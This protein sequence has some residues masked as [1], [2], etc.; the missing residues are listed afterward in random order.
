MKWLHISDLHFNFPGY[1]SQNLKDK[2]IDLLKELSFKADFILVTG[3]CLYQHGGTNKTRKEL[4]QFFKLISKTCS[5]SCGKIYISQGNHDVNRSDE[6]R[7]KLIDEIRKDHSLFSEKY[8]VL[9]DIGCDKFKGIYHEITGRDYESFKAFQPR[10]NNCR[11]ISINTTLLSKDREDSGNLRVCNQKLLELGKSIKDDH[12]INILIMHHGLEYLD[13]EDS[14]KFEHWMDDN[15]ID[16]VF[17]GHSHRAA[18]RCY[19]DTYREIKQI[20]AGAIVIDDYAIPSFQLCEYDEANNV[21]T[22]NLFTYSKDSEKWVPD[23]QRLRTYKDGVHSYRLPRKDIQNN[24]EQCFIYGDTIDEF[25]KKYHQRYNSDKIYSNK[26]EGDDVFNSWK[27]VS[28]LVNIGMSYNRALII[29]REVIDRITHQDFNT[30]HKIL[31]CF[32]LRKII[33][34]T[35]IN[36]TPQTDEN[37]FEVSRWAS[38][39]SRKYNRNKEILIL[40][41]GKEVEKLNYSYIKNILIKQIIDD[42]TQNACYYKKLTGQELCQMAESILSFLK[43]MEIFEIRADVL[44]V[45]VKE[46]MTQKPHPWLVN[47]NRDMLI[48]YHIEQA[49][50]HVNELS[51][52]PLISSQIEAAYHICSLFMVKYDEYIGCDE[53]SPINSLTNAVNWIHNQNKFDN[54]ELPILRHKLI[55]LKKDLEQRSIEYSELR[56]ALNILTNNI[57]KNRN[58]TDNV[59]KDAIYTLWDIIRKLLQPTISCP[60]NNDSPLE[61]IMGIFAGADGFSVKTP[62]RALP[63]CFW[64]EPY[65]EKYESVALGV[66]KQI[67]VAVLNDLDDAKKVYSYFYEENQGARL[68]EVVFVMSD[69]SSFTPE[70]RNRVR[71]LFKTKYVRCI[72]VQKSNYEDISNILDWRKAFYKVL[73]ISKIS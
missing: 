59:T 8:E 73:Q 44:L 36:Y 41:T 62:L 63:N 49:E 71:G 2:L 67:L 18:L 13:A 39:Y 27:I 34:E 28:S 65:W 54:D 22:C 21:L 48:K 11:I 66:G 64:F 69:Y 3:D 6:N 52:N 55:Q 38:R 51:E 1:D 17:C 24:S 20:T 42:T 68:T 46:Y 33:F 30:S 35:I 12:K 61:T 72:F 7:N 57:V 15:H 31:S 5:C 58:V 4:V 19:S 53:L 29:T 16:V 26:Y 14:K 40:G 56:N 45:L 23:N 60:I 43:N 47:N 9:S 25:N 32:E 37:E 70:E 10:N 50:K